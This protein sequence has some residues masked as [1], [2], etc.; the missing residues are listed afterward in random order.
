M[1]RDYALSIIKGLDPGKYFDRAAR[2]I[3]GK[4]SYICPACQNGSGENGTGF[5]EDPKRPGKYHCFKCDLDGD[6]LDFIGVQQNLEGADLFNYLYQREGLSIQN[7]NSQDNRPLP[8]EVFKNEEEPADPLPEIMTAAAEIERVIPYLN[9]RGI[10]AETARRFNLGYLQLYIGGTYQP[11]MII[12]TGPASYTARNLNPQAKQRFTA[13]GKRRPFNLDILNNTTADDIIYLLE[14]EI[15]ALSVEELGYK[16]IGL[17]NAFNALYEKLREKKPPATIMIAEDNDEAGRDKAHRISKELTD[18]GIKHYVI[19]LSG[20]HKD[21]NELLQHD[22]EELARLLS[23]GADLG[24]QAAAKEHEQTSAGANLDEFLN[25]VEQGDYVPIS[26]TGY[27]ELDQAI[28]GGLYWGLYV[29]GAISSLGKT[30]YLL[31]LMDQVAEQGQDALIFSLEMSR[32]ELIAKSISRETYRQTQAQQLDRSNA[33]TTRGVMDKRKQD[34]FDDTDRRI[35]AEAID[36]YRGYA[37]R[38]YIHEGQGNISVKDIRKAISDH[39]NITG[40]HPVVLIDYLQLITPDNDRWSERQN[41]D[42]AISN[43][44]IAARDYRVPIIAVSSVSRGAYGNREASISAF[45]ESGGI[46]YGADTAMILQFTQK[47]GEGK[48]GEPK[49][50]EI[51]RHERLE[52]QKTPREVEVVIV[53]N[54][55]GRSGDTVK[56]IYYPEF[57]H[58]RETIQLFDPWSEDTDEVEL[59]PS[60]TGD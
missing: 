8:V 32:H 41:M 37:N 53:K 45:K 15:D 9:S 18:I 54:R 46:E 6:I 10:S 44:R 22:R 28:G 36:N 19:S 17:G 20:D 13:K 31:Q 50:H 40:K 30:T 27:P 29:L 60:G 39:I 48:K 42:H 3:Q 49:Q 33:K 38:I 51:D 2:T 11:A 58:F 26:T 5:H 1:N 7:G 43:L 21:A 25:A 47:A 14:G 24:R 52:K 34:Y 4:P 35:L 55:N 23:L 57:N 56:Y 16:A 59:A 12:P